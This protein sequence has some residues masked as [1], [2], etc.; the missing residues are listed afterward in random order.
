M[1]DKTEARIALEARAEAL[2]LKFP[3]NI[4][5]EKL[6]ERVKEAEA[7]AAANEAAGGQTSASAQTKPAAGAKRKRS[8]PVKDRLRRDG[9]LLGE[10][11]KVV[12]TAEE[13]AQLIALGV[14]EESDT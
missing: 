6:E 5:D 12:L 10:G 11:D 14:L 9:K 7:A 3:A 2:D 1:T 8:Y 13:A 4:G